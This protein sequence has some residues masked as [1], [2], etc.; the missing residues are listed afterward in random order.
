MYVFGWGGGGG[1]QAK[2]LLPCSCIRDSLT[3]DIVQHDI[4]LKRGILIF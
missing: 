4:V 2:Y 3:F 1:V